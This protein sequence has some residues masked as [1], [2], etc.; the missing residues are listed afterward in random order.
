M[1]DAALADAAAPAA[2]PV[3]RFYESA[4]AE[5][6]PDGHRILLDGRGVKTP[7]RADLLLPGAA[8]AEEIA[9]EWQAQG[10]TIDPRAMKL[11]GLANAAIDRI[12]P[13][14]AAFAA[15]LAA[16]GESDLLCYRAE[17]PER[18][19]RR[20][21]EAW[22]PLLGWARR[23]YDI[24]FAVTAGLMHIPQPEATRAALAR[25]MAARDAFALAGLAPLVTIGGSLV[26]ALALAEGEASADQAFAA[27]TLDEAWQA[28]QWGADAEA[29]AT[30]AA[31]EA[32]FKAAARFLSLLP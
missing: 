24:E 2:S 20:Q 13:D 30:L 31:R 19:A 22:D 12:A 8:L 28:E 3:K 16:Y 21:A 15:G 18:L 23:R 5:P 10:E 11:T 7:A 14:P 25:A 6:G 29:T 32:D 26:A 1:A 27:V 9:A 4:R 17:I